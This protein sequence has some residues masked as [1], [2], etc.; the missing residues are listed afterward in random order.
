MWGNVK[1]FERL[2]QQ[3]KLESAIGKKLGFLLDSMMNN[4]K[5]MI[6][7]KI[8]QALGRMMP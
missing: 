6:G 8:D 2:L 4:M 1:K 5:N 3:Q 7:A